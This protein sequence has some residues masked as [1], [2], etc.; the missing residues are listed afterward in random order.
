MLTSE[1][2]FDEIARKS[3]EWI[4]VTHDRDVENCCE[5]GNEATVS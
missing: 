3:V 5:H 4:D 1:F 2:N